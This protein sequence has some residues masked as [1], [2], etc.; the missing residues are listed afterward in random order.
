MQIAHP[1]IEQTDKIF[2]KV[3]KCS[4]IILEINCPRYC[5]TC[6]TNGNC[7][8]CPSDRDLIG[9]F[10]KCKVGKLE[11]GTHWCRSNQFFS[12]IIL[13]AYSQV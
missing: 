4:F 11:S 8:T 10:C 9:T 6:D 12:R 2:V 3:K 1:A 5:D 7:L 13:I